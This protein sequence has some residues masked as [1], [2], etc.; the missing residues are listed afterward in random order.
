MFGI[1]PY[2]RVVITVSRNNEVTVGNKYVH[3][4]L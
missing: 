1:N 4:L 3:E 2:V